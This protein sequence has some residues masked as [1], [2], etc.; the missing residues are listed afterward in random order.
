MEAI[1]VTDIIGTNFD[2]EDAILLR[3]CI[4][5]SLR[6]EILLDFA[7]IFRVPTTFLYCLLTDLINKN[8]RD[9]IASHIHVKNLTNAIDYN[10]VLLG[11]AFLDDVVLNSIMS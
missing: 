9:Y 11:T 2:K 1:K 8:G 7:G 5:N 3:S 4:E 10:R 6:N